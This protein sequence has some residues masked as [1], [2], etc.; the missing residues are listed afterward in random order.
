MNA[1]ELALAFVAGESNRG[2]ILQP[3]G[4]RWPND[5]FDRVALDGLLDEVPAEAAQMLVA[6]LSRIVRLGGEVTARLV[7]STHEQPLRARRLFLPLFELAACTRVSDDRS[8]TPMW[9]ITA[10]RIV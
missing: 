7:A 3:T 1:T 6:E 5:H 9:H 8:S 10:R 2:R 4:D